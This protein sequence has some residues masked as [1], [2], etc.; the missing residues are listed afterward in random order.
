MGPGIATPVHHLFVGPGANLRAQGAVLH[1]ELGRGARIMAETKERNPI[2]GKMLEQR[3]SGQG[4]KGVRLLAPRGRRGVQGQVHDLQRPESQVRDLEVHAPR[5]LLEV[6]EDLGQVPDL[7]GG[8]R[9]RDQ[10]PP[11]L[12][13]RS[14][15]V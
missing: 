10:R 3:E 2:L 1:R 4:R 12:I 15:L 11:L 5:H 7:Q 8:H 13:M 14:R 6:R 9:G